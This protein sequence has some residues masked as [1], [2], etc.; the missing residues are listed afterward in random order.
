MLAPITAFADN[1]ED[2]KA[3]AVRYVVGVPYD[4]QLTLT[5]FQSVFG[6]LTCTYRYSPDLMRYL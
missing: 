1:L 6:T 3:A 2:L 5:I 4:N